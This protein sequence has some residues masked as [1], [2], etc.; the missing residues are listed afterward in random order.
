MGITNPNTGAGGLTKFTESETLYAGEYYYRLTPNTAQPDADVVYQP[1]G[2]GGFSLQ[3]ADG[4][5]VGGNA[6]GA[7]A[8][9]LNSGRVAN[10][11]VASGNYAFA[12]GYG[13]SPSGHHSF[14]QGYRNAPSGNYAFAQGLLSRAPGIATFARGVQAHA[15]IHGSFAQTGVIITSLGDSQQLD[16][17]LARATTSTAPAI[18]T[19]NN[20]VAGVTNQYI[21][22]NNQTCVLEFQVACKKTGS[23]TSIAGFTGTIVATRGASA[24]ATVVNMSTVNTLVNPDGVLL[25]IT[26]DTT[27][28]GVAFTVTTPA[29]DWHTVANIRSVQVIKS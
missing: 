19:S 26:A 24:A 4:T 8:T 29:G 15:Y 12:Q 28:G 2:A 7:G 13:N 22:Q 21:L 17:I 9:D 11:E 1:K 3:Q 23:T 6:R 20:D 27:N 25:E 14:G 18:L 10:T 5:T 16:V